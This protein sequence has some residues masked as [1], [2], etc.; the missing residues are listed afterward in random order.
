MI[1]EKIKDQVFIFSS[2]MENPEVF[3]QGYCFHGTDYIFGEEGFKDFYSEKGIKVRGGEDGC[4]VSSEKIKNDLVFYSDFSGN[5]KIFYY[6]TPEI[7][8]VS[9]S[10]YLIAKH[11]KDNY[12][13]L[14]INYAQLAAIGVHRGAVFN[15][16]YSV[17]TFIE[18]IKLLPTGNCLKISNSGYSIS[19]LPR[20]VEFDS[21]EEGLSLF[22]RT[23]VARLSGLLD[24]GLNIQSD[25]TGGA[26]SRT[27]FAILKKATELS[28][29]KE[30]LP[31]FRSGSTATH[32]I[33]LEIANMIG[34]FYGMPINEKRFSIPNVFS[35]EES[36]MSWKTLCLGVYHP[37]YFPTSGPEANI[38]G[39]G[40]A[41]AENH[42]HF[43]RY[44]SIDELIKVSASKLSPKWLSYNF[45]AE[46]NTET[47]RM[48]NIGSNIDPMILH[49]RAY[50][51]RMHS[52]R[53]PQYKAFFNPLGSKLLEDVSEVAGID[54]LKSGQINYDLMFTLLPSILDIPF[55]K[56]AKA[57]N[58]VRKKNLTNITDFGLIEVGKVYIGNKVNDLPK[59]RTDSA[60]KLLAA[61]F[62]I[63]K[64]SSFAKD[65]FGVDF[66]DKAENVMSEAIKNNRFPH[67][68]DGQGVVAVIAAGMFG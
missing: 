25:L 8:V 39:L 53:T 63:A 52:G 48:R 15:Q 26:D 65:F 43:Y 9:N 30:N 27:V 64:Q 23:W 10:V 21:Y 55:D 42:R 49:Y 5:K 18:N 56:P 47:K 19:K 31:S 38:V 20:S 28:K 7:W 67:A 33:D 45:I 58:E 46:L 32:T 24:H 54:R 50:R 40:G 3:F 68:I 16:L 34:N 35:G 2:N 14:N 37:V 22:I 36:Y 51:N 59:K 66:I 57:M 29:N 4:Y 60:L 6:W 13:S 44:E 11:L 1:N 61:D 62:Q 17:N 12:V 41:G